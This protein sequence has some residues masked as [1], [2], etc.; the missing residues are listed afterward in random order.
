MRLDVTAKSIPVFLLLTFPGIASAG[1]IVPQPW[2]VIV[3]QADLVGIVECVTAG[4][5][6]AEYRIVESWRGP[7]AGTLVTIQGATSIWEPTLPIA[8]VGDRSLVAAWK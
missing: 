5:V 4:E 7:K 8:L 1:M 6:V 2:Q 3:E